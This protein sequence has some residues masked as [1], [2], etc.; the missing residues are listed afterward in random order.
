MSISRDLV[1]EDPVPHS[2][3][4]AVLLLRHGVVLRFRDRLPEAAAALRE[5][6]TLHTA[7]PRLRAIAA[8]Q[9]GRVLTR[10]GDRAGGLEAYGRAVAAIPA[11]AV[12]SIDRWDRELGLAVLAGIGPDAAAAAVGAGDARHAVELLEQARATLLAESIA[13]RRVDR[14]PASPGQRLGGGAPSASRAK[15]AARPRRERAGRPAGTSRPGTASTSVTTRFQDLTGPAADGVIVV[16]NVSH[17]RCD[18]L[19]ITSDQDGPG[20]RV[21]PLGFTYDDAVA[22]C[23]VFFAALVE[24]KR[25]GATLAERRAAWRTMTT[26]L[27]W[28][29]QHV[30]SPVMRDIDRVADPGARRL[31]DRADDDPPHTGTP[32]RVWWCPTGPMAM[33]PLHACGAAPGTGT[34]ESVLDR[35]VSS[36]IPSVTALAH[37]RRTAAAMPER[38]QSSLV[39]SVPDPRG[40]AAALEVLDRETVRIPAL[41][42]DPLTL[43]GRK[44]KKKRVLREMESRSLLHFACHCVT[45][46]ARPSAGRLVLHDH[47]KDPLTVLDV[48]RARLA[49]TE[50]VCL[51]AC[52]TADS[53]TIVIDESVHVAGAF[54]AAGV[55]HVIGTLWPMTDN[56]NSHIAPAVYASLADGTGRL[57]VRDAARA[58]RTHVRGLRDT[59]PDN[60]ALW[61]NYIHLGP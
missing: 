16:V 23:E 41:L 28:L 6:L 57:R 35:A 61:A 49:R 13:E 14:P 43:Q 11:V 39:V 34:G 56:R 50:L 18:A 32:H 33:L 54:L 30:G 40:G 52:S 4:L 10:S 27:A 53:N 31:A 38:P 60:P 19:L 3:L 24:A 48:S 42:P 44:A 29:W 45:D 55:P 37:A 17:I 15:A 9:L 25:Y 8:S 26:V 47:Q 46:P 2:P 22:Q 21:L 51:T 12:R 5:A 36:V 58:L 59:F 1:N 7:D 20:V